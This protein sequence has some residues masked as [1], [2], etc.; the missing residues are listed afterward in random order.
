MK[1]VWVLVLAGLTIIS[2]SF[3]GCGTFTKFFVRDQSANQSRVAEVG[4]LAEV[5]D[6]QI[7]PRPNPA[8]Q[9]AEVVLEKGGVYAVPA[10][11][12]KPESER[13]PPPV[14]AI[15]GVKDQEISENNP[16]EVVD[17]VVLLPKEESFSKGILEG[18]EVNDWIIN[19][20]PGLEARAHGVK[21]GATKVS[22]YISGTPEKT[23][24]DYIKV[25]IPGDYLQGGAA[26][27]FLSPTEEDS[28]SAW[29]EQQTQSKNQ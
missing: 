1:N 20:P 17:V 24:R 2:L 25:N 26:R 9:S 5:P 18:Y 3:S 10:S 13:L 28:L 7:P 12:L 22:I 8:N 16:W 29:E 19:L 23:G 27:Q 11:A 14:Y 4:D 6:I 15:S 21:K